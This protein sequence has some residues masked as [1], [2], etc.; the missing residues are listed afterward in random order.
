M[1]IAHGNMA[2]MKISRVASTIG[3]MLLTACTLTQSMELSS[4]PTSRPTLPL[5]T[6]VS[7]NVRD[8]HPIATSSPAPTPTI[9]AYDC[10]S[11][12]NNSL[13]NYDVT[14]DMQYA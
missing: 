9:A 8:A 12:R 4:T 13:T 7:T 5:S 10:S 6:L 1:S 14:A 2:S 3:F 11:V